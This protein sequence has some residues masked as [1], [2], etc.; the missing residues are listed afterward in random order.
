MQIA[1]TSV[2]YHQSEVQLANEEMCAQ[3]CPSPV[4]GWPDSPS[5]IPHLRSNVGKRG[6]LIAL[7]TLGNFR[8]EPWLILAS[9]CLV[10]VSQLH[11]VTTQSS[12][13][14]SRCL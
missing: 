2:S 12:E 9:V 11:T 1:L 3:S 7:W 5:E 6:L 13:S 8:G 4:P 10:H 14:M